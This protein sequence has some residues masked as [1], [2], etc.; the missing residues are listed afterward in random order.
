MKEIKVGDIFK[1]KIVEGR[2]VKVVNNNY[3]NSDNI[4]YQIIDDKKNY[5]IGNIYQTDSE[6]FL[7]TYELVYQIEGFEV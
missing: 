5:F 7:W 4:E 2:R 1:S 6:D 3:N